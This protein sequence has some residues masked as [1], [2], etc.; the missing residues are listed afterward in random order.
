MLPILGALVTVAGALLLVLGI[1]SFVDVASYAID[2]IALFGLALAVDYSLLMV[3]R[4]RE[5]RAAGT[6]VPAAV[7]RTVAAA[8]RTITFSALTVIA[9]LAGLFAFG[10]PTFSSLAI[11]GIATTAARAGRRAHP[12]SPRCWP[13]GAAR[14]PRWRRRPPRTAPFGRLARRVQRR[15]VIVARARRRD[16]AG[17]RAAIPVGQLRQRDP[18]TLPASFESRQVDDTLLARFP[19]KQADPIQVVAQ[20]PG[21]DPPG[22]AEAQRIGAMPGVTAVTVEQ[23]MSGDCP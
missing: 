3:N 12:R 19:G 17:G 15:P 1:T 10:D 22:A 13:A 14:S 8:G 20:L 5:E 9:S 2:V 7:E 23:A 21:G 18:R 11:G 4:F 6:D 16:P